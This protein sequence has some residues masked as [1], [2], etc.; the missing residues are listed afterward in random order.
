M[1]NVDDDR[2]HRAWLWGEA[3]SLAGKVQRDVEAASI[4]TAIFG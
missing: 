3:S 4:V 1:T 2:E